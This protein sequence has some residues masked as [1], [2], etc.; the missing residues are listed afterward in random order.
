MTEFEL[1]L[2][3]LDGV[4]KVGGG[5]MARC[6]CHKDL[7]QSLSVTEGKDGKALIYCH[8]GCEY[9]NIIKAM[10]LR[11]DRNNDTPVI[12]AIYDYTDAEG[13]SLYQVVRFHP[14]NFKQR[15]YDEER[16]W[17]WNLNG[18]QPTLYH[19]P[20]LIQAITEGKQMFIVEGEKDADNL[21][22]NG[23]VATTISGGASTKWHPSL[24][25]LFEG[26]KV[27][28]IPDNDDAGRKYAKY[29]ADMIYGWCSSLK[30]IT[31]PSTIG[32]ILPVKDVSD[33]LNIPAITIDN[34]LN[35]VYN[36][37]EYIPT[38]AVTRDE[39]N[40]WRGVNQYLWGLLLKQKT[41][42]KKRYI[43]YK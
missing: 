11:R 15:R 41:Y 27:I 9:S 8:A 22:K 12:T 2:S 30:I 3:R 39:F 26:A 29:V 28:I 23:Q 1:A 20:E 43:S 21:R 17:V 10:D 42:K 38:G 33:Y 36:T 6:P 7:K 40:S 32:N 19:L 13:K 25:P 16:G 4:R 34:L 35:I 31:L 14:K 5:F 24:V 37:G 18:I